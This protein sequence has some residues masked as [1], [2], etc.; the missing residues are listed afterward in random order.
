MAAPEGAGRRVAIPSPERSSRTFF[1]GF[2]HAFLTAAETAGR[3]DRTIAVAER[4]VRLRFAGDSLLPLLFPAIE[5]LARE[6]DD[7]GM[8]ICIWDSASTGVALPDLPWRPE[9][10]VER[11]EI[12][13][14]EA[15]FRAVYHGGVTAD[16]A[17]DFIAM[18]MLDVQGRRAIF[19]V[20]A[21][22]RIPWW[23][24]SSPLR[25]IFHWL[26][27]DA[28]VHMAHAGAVTSHGGAALLAGAAG[29]G[30]STASVAALESGLGFAGDDY[31][32]VSGGAP[33]IVHSLYCT[34]KLSPESAALLP[35]VGEAFDDSVELGPDEK[36][37]LNAARWR[38]DGLA[39]GTPIRALLLP[40]VTGGPTRLRPASP[41]QALLALAPTTIY[42]LPGNGSALRPLAEL[43]R[44]V[45]THVLELGPD[46]SEVAGTI[47]ELLR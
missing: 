23:E 3:R 45:P 41:G 27:S 9:E 39:T 42:Q 13:G 4:P 31:V 20:A 30:K 1:D 46:L 25:V 22:E 5:H 12:R 32:V 38:P 21:P 17:S 36:L 19:W 47:E 14:L 6:A 2:H 33:P 35:N 37:V 29:S 34:A 44:Q 43:V 16:P 11:G 24:R 26:L 40:R 28:G 15:G 10:V 7:P 18:S 8:E